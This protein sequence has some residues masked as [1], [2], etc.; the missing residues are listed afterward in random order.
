M[1]ITQDQVSQ[2]W[3]TLPDI[4]RE[5][6]CSEINSDFVWKTCE[7]ENVPGKKIY[8][9][10]RIT[11]YVLSGFIHPGDM[12][13]E[14]KSELNLDPKT[15][16]AIASALDARIFAP[17]RPDLDKI[18]QPLSSLE[19]G[20]KII[21][22]IGPTPLKGVN[23]PIPTAR[24]SPLPYFSNTIPASAPVQK[25][26]FSGSG[27]SR[28]TPEEPVVKLS[29]AS[30]PLPSPAA[31]P[32]TPPVPSKFSM[33]IAGG[34]MDE[35]ER[36]SLSPA[37]VTAAPAPAGPAPMII[38]Q[39][40]AFKTQQSVPNF[41]LPTAT[42]NI[43]MKKISN[44]QPVRAAVL[45]LG[46]ASAPVT[47]KAPLSTPRVVHYTDYKS[48]SPESP[49]APQGPRRV[50]DMTAAPA[51]QAPTQN[52]IVYKDY[53]AMPAATPPKPPAPPTPKT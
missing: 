51:P 9:I 10:A 31:R 48:P 52:K 43:D 11:G 21:Q 40:D 8:D 25:P 26:N 36:R 12:A 23:I 15:C 32:A 5:A 18:Y 53:S 17:L 44:T 50:T 47:P 30:T 6:L 7:Q 33:P 20:P 49:I 14:L 24:P 41:R 45:E 35:F 27:W 22:D 28:L 13:D 4:L 19:H 46:N 1:T 29:Q 39:D 42:E 34:T 3:D 38:H 16:A 37:P 2:R